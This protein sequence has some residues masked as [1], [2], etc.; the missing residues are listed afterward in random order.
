[1]PGMDFRAI[2]RA[3]IALTAAYSMALQVLLLAFVVPQAAALADPF[4]VL[5]SKFGTGDTGL[6]AKHE[7]PCPAVCAAMGHGLT[8]ALP[9]GIAA[10][11]M[12]REAYAAAVPL[13]DWIA[14]LIFAAVPLLPRG[15]PAF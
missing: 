7:I 8:G 11:D 4:T 6:P 3:V 1:M 5:C 12:L 14:P 10:V 2:R 13:I 15:P 9:A